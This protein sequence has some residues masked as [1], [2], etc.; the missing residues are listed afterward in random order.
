M[1]G[2]M[3]EVEVGNH[4][5]RAQ[6]D[7]WRGIRRPVGGAMSGRCGS[8]RQEGGVPPGRVRVGWEEESTSSSVKP[9]CGCQMTP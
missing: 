5:A 4:P 1:S 8:E 7:G 9:K 2:W 6:K 3:S